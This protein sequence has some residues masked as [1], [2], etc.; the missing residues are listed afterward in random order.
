MYPDAE[1][2]DG[3]QM[4]SIQMASVLMALLRLTIEEVGQS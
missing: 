2:P 3:D 1:A 4:V